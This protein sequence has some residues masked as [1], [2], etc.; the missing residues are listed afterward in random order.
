[1]AE[2]PRVGQLLA[3]KYRLE[4]LLGAG[5][6]GYVYRAVNEQVGR[7]VAIKLLRSEH[8]E[9][10]G[11]V[12]RFLREAR[13][14]NLVRHANVVDV[15]DLG[16]TEDGV[17]FLVQEL[18]DGDDLAHHLA[19]KGGTLSLDEVEGLVLP[20]IDAVAEAHARGVVHRDIKPDNV[21]V[22]RVG[23]K[24]VPKLL[25]FGI[26]K[27]HTTDIR[28]TDVGVMMG[29]PAYM[30]PEQVRGARD[31]DARSD[32]WAL[33]VMLFE[34]LSGRL[35]FAQTEAPALFVAIVT[36]DAPTLASVAPSVPA[37]LS[38]VVERCLRKKPDDR[39]PTAAELARD[40]RHALDGAEI[41]PTQRRSVVP[42]V[43]GAIPELDIP[44][45][46]GLPWLA[47]RD[48]GA[49][50]TEVDAPREAPPSERLPIAVP[51]DAPPER[52]APAAVSPFSRGGH[53]T[54]AH[55]SATRRAPVRELAATE[56]L[57]EGAPTGRVVAIS[58]VGVAALL[59][60]AVLMAVFH[61]PDGWPVARFFAA[62]TGTFNLVAQ[63]A[64]AVAAALVG[65]SRVKHAVRQWEGDEAGGVRGALVTS[66]IAA[67][68]FFCAVEL[69]RAAG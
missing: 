66:A 9:N 16:K 50:R 19:K 33:G 27:V 4:A 23:T 58:G 40:L 1:M 37:S 45:S 17:P 65:G 46:P 21:F 57:G 49:S 22:S 29:T 14:A 24:T 52:G 7:A 18:L 69:A 34:V 42:S 13:T 30:P 26:S 32:I 3:G 47:T 61:R 39:Y 28:A 59:G 5:A 68:A 62:A 60:V 51:I 11:V 25:D 15:V 10:E 56:D 53:A 63:G 54:A 36:D 20:I 55:P 41:E 43:V 48:F 35:P 6:M 31:A 12:D 2:D 64:M 67:A 44:A 38:R 8:A